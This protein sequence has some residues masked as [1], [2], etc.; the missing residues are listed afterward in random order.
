MSEKKAGCVEEKVVYVCYGCG[1]PFDPSE[2]I[3]E[4]D[5][6]GGTP[7]T[8]KGWDTEASPCCLM[9]FWDNVMESEVADY[10]ELCTE[11][12]FGKGVSE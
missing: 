12:R 1:K 2:I 4:K 6:E 3:K 7:E 10:K 9:G 5:Y 11:A 8:T